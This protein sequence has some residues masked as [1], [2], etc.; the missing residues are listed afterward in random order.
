[1]VSRKEDGERKI[2]TKCPVK[3]DKV[4]RSCSRVDGRQFGSKEE[5]IFRRI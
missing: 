3:Y 1:M 5:V 4:F 2:S